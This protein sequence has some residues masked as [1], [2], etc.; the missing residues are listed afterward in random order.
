MKWLQVIPTADNSDYEI[1]WYCFEENNSH[2]DFA[3]TGSILTGGR[4][5]PQAPAVLDA[6][7]YNK[8]IPFSYG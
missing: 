3:N 6:P 2:P 7:E 4:A 8:N 1:S 5:N